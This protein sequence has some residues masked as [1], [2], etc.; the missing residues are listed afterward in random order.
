[1]QAGG[2]SAMDVDDGLQ[3]EEWVGFLLDPDEPL[4]NNLG[5]VLPRVLPVVTPAPTRRVHFDYAAMP[6]AMGEHETPE[7]YQP[8][9]PPPPPPNPP[10]LQQPP[11]PQQRPPLQQR[12]FTFEQQ[13]PTPQGAQVP[14]P[15]KAA[16]HGCPRCRGKHRPHTCGR[17]GPPRPKKQP[18]RDP[19]AEPAARRNQDDDD[20]DDDDVNDDNG[21]G[22]VRCLPAE[23]APA[24]SAARACAVRLLLLRLLLL[25]LLLLHLPN[26]LA[27]NWVTFACT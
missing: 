19:A 8:G 24:A 13:H 14:T 20:D 26:V 11:P 2:S 22:R 16:D 23:H 4:P 3:F 12:P 18:R 10:R 1:M 25:R 21:R 7:Q 5:M 9:E 15:R 17:E 6:F 27:T